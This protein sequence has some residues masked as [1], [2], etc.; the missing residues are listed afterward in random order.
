[1]KSFFIASEVFG[2]QQFP[3]SFAQN[4]TFASTAIPIDKI[5]PAMPAAVKVTGM[6]LK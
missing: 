2:Q 1:M 3:L 4:Q 5:K 6:S